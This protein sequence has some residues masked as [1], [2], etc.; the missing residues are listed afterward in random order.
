MTAFLL[1]LE[2]LT[3]VDRAVFLLHDEVGYTYEEIASI[4]ERTPA[5]YCQIGHRA[6]MKVM[7]DHAQ[8]LSGRIM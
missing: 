7:S 8:S 6:R 1:L 3:P 4:V 2:R 5:D